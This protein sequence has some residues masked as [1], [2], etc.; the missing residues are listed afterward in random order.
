MRRR[1]TLILPFIALLC[2]SWSNS[3]GVA[4][5]FGLLTGSIAG[6]AAGTAWNGD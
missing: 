6:Y 5:V 1:A 4:L 2:A 3:I